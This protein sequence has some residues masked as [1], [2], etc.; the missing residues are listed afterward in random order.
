MS[1]PNWQPAEQAIPDLREDVMWMSRVEHN[2]HTIEQYKHIDTRRYIHLD[3]NGRPYRVRV[4]AGTQVFE[5]TSLADARA[6]LTS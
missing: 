5:P 2:G 3:E 1:S 6:W 4:D